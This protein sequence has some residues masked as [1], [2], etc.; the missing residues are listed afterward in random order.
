MDPHEKMIKTDTADPKDRRIEKWAMRKAF[1]TPDDPYLPDEILWRQKEQFSDGVGYG[2]VDALRDAAEAEVSDQMFRTAESRF[3][4]GTPTTK[5][6]YR[7]RMIFEELFPSEA[8]AQ[9]VP[10]GKSIACSTERA[11]SWDESFSQ[12]AEPSGRAAGVHDASYD[13]TF[14]ADDIIEPTPATTA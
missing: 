7:Y 1:D 9:T 4:Y 11:M 6:G 13:E 12:R 8:C 10:F 14:V 2:W 5:E 3:P